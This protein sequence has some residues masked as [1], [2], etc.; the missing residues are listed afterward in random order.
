MCETRTD[1]L[2]LCLDPACYIVTLKT[3]KNGIFWNDPKVQK[4]LKEGQL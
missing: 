1:T 4:M 3:Y 2:V